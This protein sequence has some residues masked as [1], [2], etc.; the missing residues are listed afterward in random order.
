MSHNNKRITKRNNEQT[1]VFKLTI[2]SNN[3]TV[4]FLNIL[5]DLSPEVY[6]ELETNILK[7]ITSGKVTIVQ[8]PISNGEVDDDDL[9]SALTS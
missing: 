9:L 6:G 3:A 1:Q 2:S 4:G 7:L 5:D 8:Q